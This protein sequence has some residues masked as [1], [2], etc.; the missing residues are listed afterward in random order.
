MLR[1]PGC[2]ALSVAPRLR[3]IHSSTPPD[4]GKSDRLLR[5]TYQDSNLGPLHPPA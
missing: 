4:F 1:R 5:W 2:G 3:G